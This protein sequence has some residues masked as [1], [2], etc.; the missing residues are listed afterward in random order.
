[1]RGVH[2]SDYLSPMGPLGTRVEAPI[3]SFLEA[4]CGFGGSCLPKD[5]RALIAEG[6]RRNQAMPLLRAVLETNEGRSGEVVRILE[7]GVGDLGG[8]RVTV[9]GVAFKPDT[10]DVRESPAVPIV[11]KLVARGA[12][13]TLHDPAV[14]ALPSELERLDVEFDADLESSLAEVEAVVLVTRWAEYQAVPELLAGREPAPVL[15]DGR[16]MLQRDGIAAYLGI[17][18]D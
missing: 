10:D 18:V 6:A 14:R 2:L 11:E 13:V 8:R 7:S 15:V 12:V 5:L 1:M 17:G 9:L 16:R 3:T 4:G